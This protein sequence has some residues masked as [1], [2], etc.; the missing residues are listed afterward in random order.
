MRWLEVRRHAY[1]KKGSARGRGSHL[2]KEGVVAARAVGASLGPIA[3]VLTSLSPRAVETAVAM[4]FAVDDTVDM[5]SGYVPGEVDHHDQWTW[6]EPFAAYA[7]LIARGKGL[8]AVAHEN[9]E[10]WLTA[11]AEVPEGSGALIIGHGGTL[12]PA[13][14]TFAPDADHS[15]WG[16]AFGHLH[17]ARLEFDGTHVTNVEIRRLIGA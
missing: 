4:G 15:S 1:T 11:L 17:G 10:L 7:A 5:P 9:R 6:P 3:Y 16:A 13:L 12:E 2:S 14:V 8:A